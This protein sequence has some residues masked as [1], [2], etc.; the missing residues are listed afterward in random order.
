[1]RSFKQ[2]LSEEPIQI[3]GW[4]RGRSRYLVGQKPMLPSKLIGRIGPYSLVLPH[5]QDVTGEDL[6]FSAD[7]TY[8]IVHGKRIV[9]ELPTENYGRSHITVRSPIVH[10]DHAG[11]RA[12]VKDLIPKMYG[13]LADKTNKIIQSGEE[14]SK[15]GRSVWR[16][17]AG[18]RPVMMDNAR[19]G[20]VELYDPKKHEKMAYQAGGEGS[21]YS[22][23]L[24]VS[25]RRPKRKKK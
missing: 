9:G 12:R 2:Y 6:N 8:H 20:T 11:K 22:I 1:M 23:T 7:R 15:G 21:G 19:T 14:Q 18:M 13:L 5:D 24:S 16:R 17:L 10:A 3:S 4:A 25:P